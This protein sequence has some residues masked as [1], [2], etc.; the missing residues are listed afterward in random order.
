MAQPIY[1]D[2]K[3]TL[4]VSDLESGN[5]KPIL[6]S[7][8]SSTIAKLLHSLLLLIVGGL[9]ASLIFSS[10][11]SIPSCKSLVSF[12]SVFELGKAPAP[13]PITP[14][15][16]VFEIEP[17]T[18]LAPTAYVSSQLLFNESALTNG[19]S[20]DFKTPDVF[21]FTGGLL[22]LNITN[23]DTTGPV[24]GG[25]SPLVAEISIGDSAIWRTSTP[26]SR[27]NAIT[28]TSTSKNIT[29]LLSLFESSQPI[30]IT[31]LEGEASDIS[32]SLEL[33]LYN[34]T[35]TT[36]SSSKEDTPIS[37]ESL[38]TPSGPATNVFSLGE[39]V[40]S[41]KVS[42]EIPQVSS[43]TTSA[44]VSLF[45]SATEE[46][47]TY[48]KNEISAIADPSKVGPLRQIN[49]F[50]S[51]VN[52]DSIFV[53]SITPKPTLFHSD[54]ITDNDNST[55]FW[56]PLAETGSFTGLSYELDLISLLPLLWESSVSLEIVVVSPVDAKVPSLVAHPVTETP[57]KSGS[58]FISGN[59]LSWESPLI[60]KASGL[61]DVSESSQ[62]DSG[63]L[64]AP[65][66]LTPWQ[67]SFKNQIV[68]SSI[69][70]GVLSSFNFTLLDNSTLSYSVQT[71]SSAF[72]VSMKQHKK[73]I[74]S[75]L[76]SL[77]VISGNK[78]HY[79]VTDLLTDL[80]VFTKNQ[81]ATFP[82][83]LSESTTSTPVSISTKI[84]A[85]ISSDFESDVN[86]VKTKYHAKEKL[87][88]DDIVGAD[89]DITVEVYKPDSIPFMKEVEAVNGVIIKE[90][91]LDGE[92]DEIFLSEIFDE[93]DS[94]TFDLISSHI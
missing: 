90:D 35:L 32:V 59:F 16:D 1:L 74:S 36:V 20:V 44:K 89:T 80:I 3:D 37:F 25:S 57:I 27:L 68:K 94:E 19:L 76:D 38:L 5:Q 88:Y 41:G 53:G 49:V 7:K 67:P 17:P 87:S 65:P 54:A 61:I 8:R 78:I 24:A 75:E 48:Y 6:A 84:K 29:E 79:E 63:V 66:A 39:T 42:V 12:M 11:S 30:E 51:S 82:L 91:F 45:V 2:E 69:D 93:L 21:N 60:S 70:S 71:N 83:T 55:L 77:I 43:N 33:T 4:L 58:W 23:N 56:S 64:I 46:E 28:K 92:F 15:I 18:L 47:V 85:N 40:K 50:A 9:T 34:D 52:A 10:K 86:G 62:L 13:A 14:I 72:S 22:T 31:F 73:S 26:Y 81:T